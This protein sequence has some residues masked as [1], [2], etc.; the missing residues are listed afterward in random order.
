MRW[1]NEEKCNKYEHLCHAAGTLHCG[2][3]RIDFEE[4]PIQNPIDLEGE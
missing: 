2:R 4:C 1:L 3:Q